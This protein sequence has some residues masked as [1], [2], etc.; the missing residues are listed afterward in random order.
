[1]SA[2]AT[3]EKPKII[4]KAFPTLAQLEEQYGLLSDRN[5]DFE[6]MANHI[7]NAVGKISNEHW[8]ARFEEPPTVENIGALLVQLEATADLLDFFT[9]EV[10]R[11]RENLMELDVLR[12]EGMV[13][14]PEDA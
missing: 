11:L 12:R 9:G 3:A 13:R 8:E 2:S 10:K 6:E 1:M 14:A 7:L 4:V 5:N